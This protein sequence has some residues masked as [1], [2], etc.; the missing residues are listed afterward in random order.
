MK[1]SMLL[2]TGAFVVAAAPIALAQ[3]R[4]DATGK[5]MPMSMSSDLPEACRSAGKTDAQ[6]MSSTM[7]QMQQPMQDMKGMMGQMS[8][9]HK[10]LHEAMMKMDPAMMQGMMIKDP[11]LAWAC[12]MIPHHQGALDMSRALLK[13][14]DNDDARKIAEKT[15]RDQEKDIAELK[16][17]VSSHGKKEGGK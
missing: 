15:I 16:Q 17:W 3:D 11:D 6:G 9:T 14:G 5:S 2:F 7:G 10:G 4:S 13:S 8:E 12:A 1:L